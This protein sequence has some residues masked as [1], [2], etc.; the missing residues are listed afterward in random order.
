MD[1][2]AVIR[3][4]FKGE[5]ETHSV[6]FKNTLIEAQ[7]RFFNVVAADLANNEI[8]YQA[9]YIIDA[10]GLMVE[11]RVFDRTLTVTEEA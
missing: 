3:I 9:A 1:K 7:Q 10:K 4:F 5:T 11:G 2:Y 8:T 6:E